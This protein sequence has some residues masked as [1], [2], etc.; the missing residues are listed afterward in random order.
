MT[1]IFRSKRDL[2][3]VVLIWA[4]ML[5]VVFAAVAQFRGDAPLVQRALILGVS[6][7]VVAFVLSMLYS[8]RYVLDDERLRVN[9]GPIRYSIPLSAIDHVKP[10]RNPLSSP[11]ASLDR[12]LIKWD[13]GRKRIL[14]S[15]ENKMAFMED[16]KKRCAHLA[17]VGDEIVRVSSGS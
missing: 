13:G 10:S 17:R 9:C 3:I 4:G 11:A 7:I 14:I 15:P 5:M 16:L 1:Q 6:I 12:L 2:W 8:I